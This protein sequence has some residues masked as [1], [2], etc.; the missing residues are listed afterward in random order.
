MVVSFYSYFASGSLEIIISDPSIVA[1]S[2][3][4]N[5]GANMRLKGG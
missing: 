5:F 4:Y 2:V 3:Q 1:K